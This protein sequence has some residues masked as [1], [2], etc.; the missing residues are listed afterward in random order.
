MNAYPAGPLLS[1]IHEPADLR[2]LFKTEDYEEG[3]KAKL[4][5]RAPVFKGR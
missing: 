4:E 2:K 1:R 5:K 3:L